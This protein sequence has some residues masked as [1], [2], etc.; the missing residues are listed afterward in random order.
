MGVYATRPRSFSAPAGIASGTGS[1][2]SMEPTAHRTSALATNSG[3]GAMKTRPAPAA[4]AATTPT[5][6]VTWRAPGHES[7][8]ARRTTGVSA[9]EARKAATTSEGNGGRPTRGSATFSAAKTETTKNAWPS[10]G[11][12]WTSARYHGSKVARSASATRSAKNGALS[13]R[14]VVA[15]QYAGSTNKSRPWKR[16]WIV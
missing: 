4:V 10:H 12:G 5:T 1:S 8:R 13:E 3:T 2:D 7:C 9:I 6:T 11:R 15:A 16:V 14:S